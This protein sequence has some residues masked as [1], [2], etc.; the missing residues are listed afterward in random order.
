MAHMDK[1]FRAF[2]SN[3]VVVY[4]GSS[5]PSGFDD[6]VKRIAEHVLLVEFRRQGEPYDD[7]RKLNIGFYCV[8][9]CLEFRSHLSASQKPD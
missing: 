2:P 8:D 6:L 7:V 3:Q 4:D 9:E 5:C 1:H